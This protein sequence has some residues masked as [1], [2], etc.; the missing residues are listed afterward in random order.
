[1]LQRAP[2]EGFD[3]RFDSDRAFIF[4]SHRTIDPAAANSELV[5]AQGGFRATYIDDPRYRLVAEFDPLT[6]E[7]RREYEQLDAIDWNSRADGP[8]DP[9]PNYR[10][11][12]EL[13]EDF[14]Y[15]AV[16]VSNQPPPA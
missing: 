9:G 2:D 14:E 16:F 13:A 3:L 6:P 5:L 8:A 7:E 12:R 11:Y 4:G 15:L 10:R 1:M